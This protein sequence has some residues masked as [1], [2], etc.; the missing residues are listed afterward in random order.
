MRVIFFLALIVFPFRLVAQINSEKVKYAMKVE[1]FNRMKT[2]GFLMI[3]AGSALTIASFPNV[4][5]NPSNSSTFSSSTPT[6]PKKVNVEAQLM[7]LGGVG[8]LGGG[9]PLAIVGSKKSKQYQ[10]KFDELTLH[11]NLNPQQQGLA[12]SYKF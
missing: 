4:N 6:T 7:F 3:V 5:I 11:L 2:T 10:H 1:K 8:L 12:L 9:I